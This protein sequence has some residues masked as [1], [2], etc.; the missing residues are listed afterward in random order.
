MS[1]FFMSILAAEEFHDIAPPVD[2]S[3]IPPWLIFVGTFFALAITGLVVWLIA[4]K[5]KRPQPPQLPRDRALEALEQMRDQI[6]RLNPYQFSI[7]VSDILRRYVT[8]Q[9]GL[10]VTRQT[11]MEFLN[12]LAKRPQFS[13][14][15]K[16]LLEDFLNRCDLIKFARHEATAA[17]SRL[18]LEEA[19]RFVKGGQ[20]ATFRLVESKQCPHVWASVAALAPARD[21]IACVFARETRS[22]CRLDVLIDICFSRHWKTERS[23]RR[24]NSSDTATRV[25]GDFRYCP[26]ASAA[27][28][29]SHS[30]R[31]ERNRHYARARCLRLEA[32]ER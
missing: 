27:W 15:E 16:L 1:I 31:R 10:P 24:E 30:D 3:L 14:D 18:L 4:Q 19:T 26:R 22:G 20:L 11:S 6:D 12:A 23:P 17:D 9:H 13:S 8:E 29:E 2:Y 25:A 28:E 32:H 7:R 21:S 5:R